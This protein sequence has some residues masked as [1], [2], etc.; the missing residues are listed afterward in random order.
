MTDWRRL[1]A[2]GSGRLLCAALGWIF[3]DSPWVAERAWD[4]RPFANVEAL[5]RA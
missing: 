2:A 3:E 1:N 5:H 4:A